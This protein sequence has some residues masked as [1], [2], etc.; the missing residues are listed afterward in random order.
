M[1]HSSGTVGV[2]LELMLKLMLRAGAFS[3]CMLAWQQLLKEPRA[4]STQDS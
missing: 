2:L 1:V 4:D 3:Y